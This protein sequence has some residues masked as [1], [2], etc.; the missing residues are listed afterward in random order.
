MI[1]ATARA[2][3]ERAAFMINA[4]RACDGLARRVVQMICRNLNG[5]VELGAPNAELATSELCAIR[6]RSLFGGRQ[7]SGANSR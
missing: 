1:G 7:L 4:S 3:N 5:D 2:Y 6:P